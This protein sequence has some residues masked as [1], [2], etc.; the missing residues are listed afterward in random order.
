M[1][2]RLLQYQY[3]LFSKGK[4]TN[5]YT[6]YFS[7]DKQAF[8]QCGTLII[9]GFLLVTY[10]LYSLLMDTSKSFSNLAVS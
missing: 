9:P 2:L 8:N 4:F 10:R 5:G 1:L 7:G 6:N 3:H